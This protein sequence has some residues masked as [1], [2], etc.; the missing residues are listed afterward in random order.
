MQMVCYFSHR[1][2]RLLQ[3]ITDFLIEQGGDVIIH[4][5]SRNILDHPG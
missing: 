1:H 2:V 4:G 5:G 3:E